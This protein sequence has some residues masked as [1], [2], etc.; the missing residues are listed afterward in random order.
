M[1]LLLLLFLA[2]LVLVFCWPLAFFLILFWPILWLISIPFRI[3][4]AAVEALVALCI[5]LLF[6]PARILGY[7]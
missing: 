1:K 5:G 7:R 4:V 2:F 3:A 6:L